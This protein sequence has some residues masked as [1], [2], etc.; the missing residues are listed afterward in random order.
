MGIADITYFDGPN[1]DLE[2]A[3]GTAKA[4]FATESVDMLGDVGAGSR[5]AIDPFGGL[6][7]IHSSGAT[8]LRYGY[9]PPT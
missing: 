5:L 2:Y 8:G 7:E 3:T 1:E 4:G 9:L 6:H